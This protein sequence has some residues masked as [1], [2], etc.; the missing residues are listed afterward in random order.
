MPDLDRTAILRQLFSGYPYI[1]TLTLLLAYFST[2]LLCSVHSDLQEHQIYALLF[3]IVVFR[4]SCSHWDMH[5][6][7]LRPMLEC[8]PW[9]YL[10]CTHALAWVMRLLLLEHV[11][12]LPLTLRN[13]SSELSLTHCKPLSKKCCIVKPAREIF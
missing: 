12:L 5:T 1:Y 9:H 4:Y 7:K 10:L 2:R 3:H 13:C 8:A 11:A 6:P